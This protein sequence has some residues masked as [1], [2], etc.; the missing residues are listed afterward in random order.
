[1]QP[2]PPAWLH[3][4]FHGNL[5]RTEIDLEHQRYNELL[6]DEGVRLL[7]SML[8][9]L[10][11]ADDLADRR[12]VTLAMEP[13]VGPLQKALHA[14]ADNVRGKRVVLA[15]DGE[16]YFGPIEISL[17]LPDDVQML[18][19]LLPEGERAEAYGFKLP[20]K[21]LL[22]NGR[23]LL[24]E[25]TKSRNPGEES[26]A[27][28]LKRQESGQ[29]LI[30]R[31]AEV[32]RSEGPDFWEPFLRWLHDRFTAEELNDQRILP[33]GS[34]DLRAPE[35]GIFFAPDP[36]RG[37]SDIFER[38]HAEDALQDLP[39]VDQR[40]VPARKDDGNYTEL[41]T[42]LAP[43]SGPQLVR[44]PEGLDLINHA[45]TPYLNKALS[46]A[47]DAD[48]ALRGLRLA[49][50]LTDQISL[51]RRRRIR[52]KE[53]RVP[54]GDP[55]SADNWIAPAAAYL[56]PGWVDGKTDNLLEEAYGADGRRLLPWSCFQ[57]LVEGAEDREA[58]GRRM[59]AMGVDAAPKLRTAEGNR[60]APL[61]S[62]S[63][64]RLSR[65]ESVGSPLPALGDVWSDYL[66]EI[67]HRPAR[68]SSG[69]AFDVDDVVWID[70]L[71]Q[72]ESR[73]PV[74]QLMLLHARKYRDQTETVLGRVKNVRN[75]DR[76]PVPT[77]WVHAL[78][79]A[80]WAVIPTTQGFVPP[81]EAWIVQTPSRTRSDTS[82]R[83]LPVVSDRYRSADADVLLEK[84]GVS[85]LEAADVGDLVR[86][87]HY[88][89][90]RLTHLSTDDLPDAKV[91]A[92]DIYRDIQNRL[93]EDEGTDRFDTIVDHPVP[94]LRD[95]LEAV[96]LTQIDT[97]FL[98]DDPVRARFVPGLEKAPKIPTRAGRR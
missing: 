19:W 32:H 98:N 36:R 92:K 73:R 91:L 59:Q 15:A 84:I 87:L 9:H 24:E 48:A 42:K 83:I 30:E 44:R 64:K 55:D 51:E 8:D 11:N 66:E 4:H 76:T 81:S 1:M 10:R 93:S 96:D 62:D 23:E 31:G 72:A 18:R 3:S 12:L 60:P 25:L 40:A 78:R 90:G 29:S 56:G 89:A 38:L 45:V 26:R 79:S 85:P 47:V 49:L 22:T 17:P 28:F 77:M 13:G 35:D 52:A 75:R 16:T 54:V 14:G 95:D 69:Q 58:W 63:E 88:V 21:A 27:L 57:S 74:V 34:S 70:G 67:R 37:G 97:L 80:S 6:F 94:L 71:E 41:A 68:T 43:E 7:R 33:V 5:S 86:A 46:G 50:L 39:F 61:K 65:N 82:S 2:G 53:L 20:E